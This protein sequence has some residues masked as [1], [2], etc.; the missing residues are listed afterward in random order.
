MCDG[1]AS[2]IPGRL[3][4]LAMPVGITF[5]RASLSTEAGQIALGPEGQLVDESHLGDRVGLEVCSQ[6]ERIKL[7]E[8]QGAW[9]EK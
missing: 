5:C 4:G 7:D 6:L 9:K 8:E 1:V 2:D 3:S